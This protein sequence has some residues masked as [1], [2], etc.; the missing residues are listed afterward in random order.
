MKSQRFQKRTTLNAAKTR[1]EDRKLYTEFGSVEAIQ[2][3]FSVAVG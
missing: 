1:N 3:R 2:S